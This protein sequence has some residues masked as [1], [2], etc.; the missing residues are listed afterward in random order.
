MIHDHAAWAR[1]VLREDVELKNRS[2]LIHVGVLLGSDVPELFTRLNQAID[3]LP[4]ERSGELNDR[5][6]D[7]LRLSPTRRK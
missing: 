5:Q 7:S 6:G 4:P 1:R 3:N 2:G